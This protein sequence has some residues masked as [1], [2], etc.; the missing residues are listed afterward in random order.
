ML[1]LP[2]DSFETRSNALP[3]G[4]NESGKTTIL[5]QI[6]ILHSDKGIPMEERK[7]LRQVIFSNMI[8]AFKSIAKEMKELGV[9]YVN[10]ESHVILFNLSI[11]RWL[12]LW[13]EI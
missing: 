7:E 5:K 4:A 11:Y 10:K 12:I 3:V 8:V 6:R 1:P 2:Q 13:Q 9:E